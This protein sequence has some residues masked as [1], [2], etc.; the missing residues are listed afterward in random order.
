[1]MRISLQRRI[2]KC[3]LALSIQHWNW[4][5]EAATMPAGKLA[6]LGGHPRFQRRLPSSIGVRS[7][8]SYA[9]SPPQLLANDLRSLSRKLRQALRVYC[10]ARTASTI[11]EGTARALTPHVAPKRQC[12]KTF[13]PTVSGRRKALEE[14]RKSAANFA[15][16][17]RSVEDEDDVEKWMTDNLTNLHAG[18][19][20]KA[21]AIHWANKLLVRL[22]ALDKETRGILNSHVFKIV[23]RHMALAN[24]VRQ[25]NG[26]FSILDYSTASPGA[27]KMYQLRREQLSRGEFAK[28]EPEEFELHGAASFAPSAFDS[29]NAASSAIRDRFRTFRE[30]G[31]LEVIDTLAKIDICKLVMFVS[32]AAAPRENGNAIRQKSGQWRDPA[33]TALVL[34]LEPIW[35]RVTGEEK[36]RLSTV[37]AEHHLKT[38]RFVKWLATLIAD[39]LGPVHDDVVEGEAAR[40]AVIHAA[41]RT[42]RDEWV[43]YYDDLLERRDLL[44]AWLREQGAYYGTAAVERF[45]D[46]SKDLTEA[47]LK[48]QAALR[49][50]R[51]ADV[52][53]ITNVLRSLLTD[54]KKK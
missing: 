49:A 27:W 48:A 1:L 24:A 30:S 25:L 37:D 42:E 43:A 21:A 16:H 31:A 2:T 10:H 6:I 39:A 40:E 15:S 50:C 8:Y 52:K 53:R 36:V 12:R 11:D 23:R 33:L 18:S 9:K 14:I 29:A 41:G 51:D 22:E 26:L 19:R 54:K 28:L 13:I 38:S 47:T 45:N 34:T 4:A 5:E 35:C 20:R 3:F 17:Y 7:L 44:Q 32:P 46:A